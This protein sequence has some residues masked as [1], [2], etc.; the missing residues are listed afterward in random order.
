MRTTGT[1]TLRWCAWLL[2]GIAVLMILGD[3]LDWWL[4]E[5]RFP[6]LLT[7]LATIV[8]GNVAD[9]TRALFDQQSRAN[10]ATREAPT[11]MQP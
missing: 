8:A 5:G 4:G 11:H 1:Q 2:W 6:H 7:S 9:R 10:A 3:A